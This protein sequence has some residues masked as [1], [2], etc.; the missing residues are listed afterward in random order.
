MAQ[1]SR[2]SCAHNARMAQAAK[3]PEAQRPRGPEAQTAAPRRNGTRTHRLKLQH[4]LVTTCQADCWD[5]GSAKLGKRLL[6][7]IIRVLRT[8]AEHYTKLQS[9]LSWAG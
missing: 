5:G 8:E 6:A 9:W 4:E 2:T 1:K 7:N 3:H